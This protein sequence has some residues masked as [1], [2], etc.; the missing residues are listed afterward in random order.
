MKQLLLLR[1]AQAEP[2][3]PLGDDF[4]R[5]LSNRGQAE[6]TA[7]GRYLHKNNLL[8]KH[9]LVSGARRAR[10]TWQAI[11]AF[12]GNDAKETIDDSL[13]SAAPQGLLF[14][15]GRFPDSA[16]RC[17][18]VAHNPAI[19]ALV[20]GLMGGKS[21]PDAAR[22]LKQDMQPATLALLSFPASRWQDVTPG[23]GV[24]ESFRPPD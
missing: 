2:K 21:N 8:P 6:A 16:G 24:L 9:A 5:P 15:I 18:L 20:A 1:H 4:E 7:V 3:P 13:Y 10:E 23:S 22:L 17:L 11:A 19:H 12:I 14:E